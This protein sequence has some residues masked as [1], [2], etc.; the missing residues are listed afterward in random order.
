MTLTSTP[1]VSPTHRPSRGRRRRTSSSASTYS[2]SPT[3][4]PGA[5]FKSKNFG[6]SFGL[7]NSL[8]FH[9][10]SDT[11]LNYQ[12]LSFSLVW[13]ISNQNKIG[14]SSQNSG[15]HFFYWIGPQHSPG[16]G[17]H[18]AR[19][20]ALAADRPEGGEQDGAARDVGGRRGGETH[21]DGKRGHDQGEVV[22]RLHLQLRSFSTE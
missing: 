11:C 8:R 15:W 4:I 2:T 18:R 6:L 16:A 7:K 17:L 19:R 20:S 5:Q 14:F 10:E 12:F 9:F 13:A 3:S 22:E 21:P 1:L